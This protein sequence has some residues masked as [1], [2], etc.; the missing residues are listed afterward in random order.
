MG[1]RGG[2]REEETFG[3]REKKRERERE[4]EGESQGDRVPETSAFI[5]AAR[6][7]RDADL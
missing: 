2:G 3:S 4:R 1:R 5:R 7:A 6:N